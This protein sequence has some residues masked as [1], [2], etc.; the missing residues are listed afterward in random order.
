VATKPAINESVSGICIPAEKGLTFTPTPPSPQKQALNANH[1]TMHHIIFTLIA[2]GLSFIGRKTGLT[3]YVI[4]ILVYYFII[5]FSWLC[6]LVVI[7]HFHYL[8]IA[9]A[10]FTLG[11][12]VGCRNFQ[13]YSDWL[14]DKSV[15]FLLSFNSIGSNY[16]ASSVWICVSL[17]LGIYALLI[18]LIFS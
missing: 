8:K 3:Y 16:I 7:F 14:F 10:V 1:I 6:L 5:P 15:S 9:F 12:A 11:F 4:N 2:N 18:Y 13:S 17:P